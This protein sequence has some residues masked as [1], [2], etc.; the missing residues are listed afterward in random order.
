[1]QSVSS[2][3]W[4]HI[5]VFISYGDNDYTTG[6][7]IIM[8]M[9]GVHTFRKVLIRK[10]TWKSQPE[11][12]LTYIEDEVLPLSYYTKDIYPDIMLQMKMFCF[13]VLRRIDVLNIIVVSWGNSPDTN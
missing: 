2:R 3:I 5:A 13:S 9:M 12:E 11:F 4:T 7:S 6:T 1:M 8:M 10:W